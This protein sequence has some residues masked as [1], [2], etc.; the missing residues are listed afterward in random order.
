MR[1][2]QRVGQD[3]LQGENIDLYVTVIVSIVLVA[4]H[5]AFKTHFGNQPQVALK[6]E[7]GRWYELVREEIHALWE[8]ATPWPFAQD[9]ECS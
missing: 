6:P 4:W 1:W 5:Y 3:L 2:L 9:K 8:N 7:D